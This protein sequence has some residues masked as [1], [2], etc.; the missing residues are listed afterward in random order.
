MAVVRQA[1]VSYERRG[2][3]ASRCA[4][5]SVPDFGTGFLRDV[6]RRSSW[7]TQFAELQGQDG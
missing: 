1:N 4:M 6:V 3:P 5:R 7:T 2:G